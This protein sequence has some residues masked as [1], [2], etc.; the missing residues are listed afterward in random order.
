VDAHRLPLGLA[1]L[2]VADERQPGR[3]VR[4]A[5]D[6]RDDFRHH[7]HPVT[8]GPGREHH[9]GRKDQHPDTEEPPLSH[10]VGEVAGRDL[11]QRVGDE[12]HS[13]QRTGL[14]VADGE[15]VDQER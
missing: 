5:P 2:E 4:T 3:V 11:E 1:G 12:K 9:T 10:A 14:A 7:E 15:V 8:P 6:A 13:H